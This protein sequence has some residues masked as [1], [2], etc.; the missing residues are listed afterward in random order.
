[1]VILWTLQQP[2]ITIALVGARNVAQ[3]TQNAKALESNITDEEIR[4]INK[5]LQELTLVE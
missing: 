4:L 1:L 5:N 2:G 3:A